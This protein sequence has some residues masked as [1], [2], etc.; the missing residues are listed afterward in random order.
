MQ[1]LPTCMCL[2][3]VRYDLQLFPVKVNK[4]AE[5]VDIQFDSVSAYNGKLYM[6]NVGTVYEMGTEG[7]MTTF[8]SSDDLIYKDGTPIRQMKQLGF[9]NNGNVIFYDDA[10]KAIRRINL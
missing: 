7:N 6:S 4:A 1:Q 10:S 8:V 2:V 5:Y 9:D 3:E